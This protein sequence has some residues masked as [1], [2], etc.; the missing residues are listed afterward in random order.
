MNENTIEAEIV[1]GE[2]VLSEIKYPVSTTDL[3]S[4]LKEYSDIPTINPELED[5]IVAEQYQFV[6][7]GHKAF[8]KA[9][10]G[11][12][13]T[14][15]QLKQPALDYGKNVD[16]I[17]KEFQAMIKNKEQELLIQ[18][19]IVEDNEARKQR[20]AEEAEEARMDNIKALLNRYKSY[21]MECIAK[22]S[23][24]IQEVIDLAELP[25][26]EI[27]EEFFD[28]AVIIY[29]ASMTQMRQMF[30]NQL[31]VENAQKIQDEADVKAREQK[32]IEDK[33][34]QDEKDAFAKQQAEFQRKQDDFARQQREQQEMIDR[35]NAEIKANE[36]LRVQE[37]ERQERDKIAEEERIERE[38]QQE[39]ERQKQQQEWEEANELAKKLHKEKVKKY[40]E[41]REK[42]IARTLKA[43]DKY[44]DNQ[45]LL[46][47]I[48]R[49]VIPNVKWIQDGN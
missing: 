48:I 47:E 35:Q 49:G 31:V 16:G 33:K 14:R 24:V 11:I 32:A 42:E 20:E 12:E 6:L 46:N 19:K 27:L 5:D 45:L 40:A 29:D 3:E 30:D 28:E 13:K 15:K 26:Q 9:R 8:V 23:K 4:L 41:N 38:R 1:E 34:L 17:A 21:P 44:T 7:K 36:M 18:R 39:I 43:I 22:S 37:I 10:T 2:I 25:K